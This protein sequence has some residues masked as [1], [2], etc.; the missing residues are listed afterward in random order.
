MLPFLFNPFYFVTGKICSTLGT[1]IVRNV[2]NVKT[3]RVFVRFF[4]KTRV[5]T[6]FVTPF[7]T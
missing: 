2:R 6:R 5:F 1:V 3:F 7:L 4:L